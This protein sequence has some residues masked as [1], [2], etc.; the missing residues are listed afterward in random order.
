[1][2]CTRSA[3]ASPRLLPAALP[4]ALADLG[5]DANLQGEARSLIKRWVAGLFG[6]R[7]A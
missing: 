2:P 6:K 1:M 3:V 5:A 7:P 4:P